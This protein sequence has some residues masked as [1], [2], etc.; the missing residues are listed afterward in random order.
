MNS[1][2][3]C[4][5]W[6][7][8]TPIRVDSM[9]NFTSRV[10]INKMNKTVSIEKS[11][12]RKM[13]KNVRSSLR[14]RCD[15]THQSAYQEKNIHSSSRNEN[16][17]ISII[18]FFPLRIS[19]VKRKIWRRFAYTALWLFVFLVVLRLCA[20]VLT[21][22]DNYVWLPLTYDMKCSVHCAQLGGFIYS[23]VFFNASHYWYILIV[24]APYILLHTN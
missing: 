21:Q 9:K 2:F 5:R 10:H 14:R 1:F 3:Y 8:R 11:K 20:Q 7:A 6:S 4:F 13:N 16:N 18:S 19:F 23:F 12:W 24:T 22:P 15:R 17:P